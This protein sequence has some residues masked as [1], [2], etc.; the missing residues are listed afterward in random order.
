MTKA[1]LDYSPEDSSLSEILEV[2]DSHLSA[3]QPTLHS[4]P[5]LDVS[6]GSSGFRTLFEA[7]LD[8]FLTYHSYL[9]EE[10]LDLTQNSNQIFGPFAKFSSPN[11]AQK[12]QR[13]SDAAKTL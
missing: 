4:C 12:L 10:R 1:V 2:L 9:G 3:P 13:I 5:A 6:N 11:L 8:S 7:N